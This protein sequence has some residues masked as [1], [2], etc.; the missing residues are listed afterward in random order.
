MGPDAGA[1]ATLSRLSEPNPSFH[2]NSMQVSPLATILLHLLRDATAFTYIVP[3]QR[4][5]RSML[6]DAGQ[7]AHNP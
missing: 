1:P 2:S 7:H 5:G 4:Q 6:H 3:P